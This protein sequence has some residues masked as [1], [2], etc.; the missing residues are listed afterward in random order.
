M[1]TRDTKADR[2]SMRSKQAIVD[3]LRV[4]VL[5]NEAKA[6]SVT[7]I[8]KEANIGRATFYAHFEGIS[9]LQR[10]IFNRFLDQ[11]ERETE[12]WLAEQQAPVDLYQ[13]LIPSQALFKIAAEKHAIFKTHAESSHYGLRALIGPLSVR[14]ERQLA[15][16]GV[17]K[18]RGDIS[19]QT[20]ATYLL[21]ALIALLIAWVLEDMPE[22]PEVMDKQFQALARPTLK[23]LV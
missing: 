23:L 12:R 16:I 17:S 22:P 1:E 2:R 15:D 4:L 21:N 11:I 5:K 8:I 18:P 10:Y 6:I 7:D 9:D 13:C 14:F 19:Q 3:A 20:I